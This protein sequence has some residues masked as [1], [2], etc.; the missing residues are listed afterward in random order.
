MR[1]PSGKNP[2]RD[3]RDDAVEERCAD[4]ER[5]QREH[6]GAAMNDRRPAA[7]EQRRAGPED[8]RDR[9]RE[10]QPVGPPGNPVHEIRRNHSE[11][12]KQHHRQP[13]DS[14]DVEAPLHVDELGIRSLV[15]RDVLRLERHAALRATAR[16]D[17][18]HLRMHRA[19]V[20]RPRYDR[21]RLAGLEK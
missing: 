9:E 21:F 12:R 8:D 4:P 15:E 16:S 7:H 5:N 20:D 3:G 10:L 1:K 19:G 2:G 13:E 14:G 18:P 6:V 17:L 11:H